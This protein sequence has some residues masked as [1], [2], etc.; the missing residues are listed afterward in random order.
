MPCASRASAHQQDATPTR[1]L[2]PAQPRAHMLKCSPSRSRHESKNTCTYDSHRCT[3]MLAF[4]GLTRAIRELCIEH[5]FA[6]P[7]VVPPNTMQCP[8]KDR[9]SLAE[10]RRTERIVSLQVPTEILTLIVHARHKRGTMR[11]CWPSLQ[12]NANKSMKLPPH[13]HHNTN[14]QR[15]A[16][17]RSI[18]ATGPPHAWSF[19][20]GR[21]RTAGPGCL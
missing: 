17:R 4:K 15:P 21:K 19:S 3:Y 6:P 14:S 10:V 20:A 11:R 9:S 1:R 5:L 18:C 7:A 12:S 8:R 2:S 16:T 13:E